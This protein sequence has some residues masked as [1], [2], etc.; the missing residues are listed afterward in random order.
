MCN[1]NMQISNHLKS[2]ATIQEVK[3]FR[4]FARH[5]HEEILKSV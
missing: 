2:V 3:V 1:E 4:K 5:V